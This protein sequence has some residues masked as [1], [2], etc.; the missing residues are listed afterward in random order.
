MPFRRPTDTDLDT[1]RHRCSL[2]DALFT[3][4]KVLLVQRGQSSREGLPSLSRHPKVNYGAEGGI[5]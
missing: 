3:S 2:E 5:D 4:T 1:Y